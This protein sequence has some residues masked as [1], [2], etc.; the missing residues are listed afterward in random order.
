MK[1]LYLTLGAQFPCGGVRILIEH[2]NRLMARGHQVYMSAL[3]GEMKVGWMPTDF[4]FVHVSSLKRWAKRVDVIVATEANT[5]PIVMELETRR[6]RKFYFVQ[7]R[8]SLFFWDGNRKWAKSVEETYSKARGILQPIVISKWLKEFL[9]EEH[10]YK[11]VPIVPNGVNREHFFPESTFPKSEKP[12]ILLAG[13]KAN[14]AKDIHLMAYQAADTYRKNIQPVELWGF[15]QFPADGDFDSFWV[16]PSQEEIRQIYSSCDVLLKA[17]RFEGRSCYG[18]EAMACGCAVVRAVDR[19]KDDLLDGYNCLLTEYGD[20]QGMY[21]NLKRVL[22]EEGL[23]E[24][25]MEN[26]L[27]YARE[28]LDWNLAID[29]LEAIYRSADLHI[30]DNGGEKQRVAFR[31]DS[32]A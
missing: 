18:P 20:A 4:R 10:G 6:A 8:E 12:R 28:K 9:E 30:G 22:H 31:T 19:G 5:A 15:S 1:I 17:S 3:N 13:H 16:M 2:A 14:E 29:K 21:D 24:R 7:M 25:L 32:G 11:D 26:G 27:E 23:R